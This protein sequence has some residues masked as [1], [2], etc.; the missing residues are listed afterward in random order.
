MSVYKASAARPFS[1]ATSNG[2][3]C[4]AVLN[5]SVI[6]VKKD[7]CSA[8]CNEDGRA[9]R[10][11]RVDGRVM[12]IS[13]GVTRGKTWFTRRVAMSASEVGVGRDVVLTMERVVHEGQVHVNP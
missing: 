4:D 11:G 10:E 9:V 8:T 5:L 7:S 12:D 2:P 1:H 3:S 6:F 13:V